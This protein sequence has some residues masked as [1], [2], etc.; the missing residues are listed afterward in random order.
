MALQ[1]PIILEPAFYA[2]VASGFLGEDTYSQYG[3]SNPLN[4]TT[5]AIDGEIEFLGGSRTSQITNNDRFD[6][7]PHHRV[8]GKRDTGPV[9]KF[10]AGT[11]KYTSWLDSLIGTDVELDLFDR[12]ASA[13]V[14]IPFQVDDTDPY[15]DLRFEAY[16]DDGFVAYLNG[17]E[18]ARVRA[19]DQLTWSSR[20]TGPSNDNGI[21]EPV[22][23]DLTEHLG[24]LKSGENLL[25]I[26]VLNRRASDDDFLIRPTLIASQS[27]GSALE[28]YDKPTPGERNA[29]GF[30]GFVED[31]SISLDH[32]IFT[33]NNLPDGAPPLASLSTPTPDAEIYFTTDG[34]I[35]GPANGT[36]YTTPVPISST[37]TLRAA[38]FADQSLPSPTATRSYIFLDDVVSQNADPAGFPSHWNGVTTDYGISQIVEDL[39]RIAGD[40]SLTV[41]QAVDSIKQSLQ[42]LPTLSIVLDPE[43]LFGPV[44][45]L[46]ANPYV[47]GRISERPASVELIAADGSSSFQ[48][49]AGVRMMGWTSRIP[50][51]SP[52]HSLRLVFRN[53]YGASRLEFP[54]FEGTSVDSFDT[55]ALRS[56]SRDSWISDYPFG[57]NEEGELDDSRPWG[58]IR[59]VATYLRDQ[60]AKQLQADMGNPAPTGS[61]VHLYLNG[62]YWGVYNPTERPDEVFAAEHFGGA[63]E[64]YEIQTFCTSPR[65]TGSENHWFELL[66][67]ADDGFDSGESYQRLLGNHPDGSPNPELAPLIDIDNFIDFLIAGQFDAADD[68]PCNFYAIPRN[69]RPQPWIS[70]H[71]LGQ[72]FGIPHGHG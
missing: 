63:P 31:V 9:N 42:S 44:N 5:N 64:D 26:H 49:D 62:L 41:D 23:F 40:A 48:V 61:F 25:A 11:F 20:A 12:N 39:P 36:R 28:Y 3:L 50:E 65:H 55:I 10:A 38:A 45:G 58:G 37:T 32:G 60:W 15:D 53:E 24:L 68:W 13:Y 2:I 6:E 35:P 22:S 54:F 72:R 52:K 33:A 4:G 17:T 19:P 57:V 29:P 47:R 34:S 46:Y 56:N 18:I 1:E 14:R 70:V 67:A 51:V 21:L 30:R 71:Y 69:G 66:N 43:D 16:H 7:K 8:P 59:S 27:T